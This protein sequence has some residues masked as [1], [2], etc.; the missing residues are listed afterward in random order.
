MSFKT[1]AGGING[2][3]WWYGSLSEDREHFFLYKSTKT[4]L[5]L[6]NYGEPTSLKNKNNIDYK[7][8]HKL[9]NMTESNTMKQ[10]NVQMSKNPRE[11]SVPW[12]RNSC[13]I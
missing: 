12:M 6:L 10:R 13:W 8:S 2:A 9:I 11:S 7:V 5:W 4:I 3:F 1:I